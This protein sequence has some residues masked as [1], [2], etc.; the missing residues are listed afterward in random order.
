MEM[1]S[2]CSI[3]FLI[4]TLIWTWTPAKLPL[5]TK[6][7][8]VQNS[9]LDVNEYMEMESECSIM[10]GYSSIHSSVLERPPNCL[11]Q[12]IQNSKQTKKHHKQIKRAIFI[13]AISLCKILIRSK[14][15]TRRI[16]KWNLSWVQHDVFV[17]EEL[18]ST[19]NDRQWL[20]LM[21]Y[22]FV[23]CTLCAVTDMQKVASV[24]FRS[25]VSSSSF[26]PNYLFKNILFVKN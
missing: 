11:C 8:S 18:S 15:K 12:S 26:R 20:P 4:R 5:F 24:I 2:E 7:Y 3:W 1:E 10:F 25:S 17:E 21:W 13:R 14:L 16:W 23:V 9:K 22:S 6:F 19:F